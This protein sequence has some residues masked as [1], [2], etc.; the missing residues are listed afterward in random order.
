MLRYAF[1]I[2][3]GLVLGIPVYAQNPPT[4]P[5]AMAA[6]VNGEKITVRDWVERMENLHYNDFLIAQTPPQINSAKGGQVALVSLI[7]S[8][9]VMQ[10]AGKTSLIATD[11]EVDADLAAAKQR[12]EIK[13]G[14]ANN[15]FSE[16]QLRNELRV[17][18]TYYNLATINQ[19]VTPDE[20]KAYYDKHPEQWGRPESWRLQMIKVSTQATADKVM[21]GL[22]AGTPFESLAV[23]YS[24]DERTKKNGGDLGGPVASTD[25]SLPEYLREAIKKLKVGE[26]T[27]AIQAPATAGAPKPA[28]YLVRKTATEEA[29]I[30]PFETVKAQAQQLAL[31]DKVGGTAAAEK[32]LGEYRK[33]AAI[34]ITLP[35]YESIVS[36]LKK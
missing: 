35:G 6:S 36:Q 30:L 20:V 10:Y 34:V 12:P 9:L 22:K 32:K 14:L 29:N 26:I 16:D 23:Q 8:R 21:A 13:Q 33:T 17:Q 3:V 24:E 31:L 25:P 2:L 15:A 27:P 18:R 28:I 11:A 19:S 5:N 4:D 7:N 1:G